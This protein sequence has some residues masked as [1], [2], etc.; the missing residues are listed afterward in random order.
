MEAAS[1]DCSAGS[2]VLFDTWQC[3]ETNAFR[4]C[5]LGFLIPDPVMDNGLFERHSQAGCSHLALL[6][7]WELTSA[8]N[9]VGR[10][11][12]LQFSCCPNLLQNLHFLC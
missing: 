11:H 12:L 4:G 7:K 2:F 5:L 6:N 8:D 1:R 10:M 9:T 3:S